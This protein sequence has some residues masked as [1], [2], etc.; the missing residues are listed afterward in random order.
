MDLRCS[1]SETRL[2]EF[3]IITLTLISSRT[4]GNAFASTYL[5]V[6]PCE[7]G[8]IIVAAASQDGEVEG[9]PMSRAWPAQMSAQQIVPMV[10][11]GVSLERGLLT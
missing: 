10:P 9:A 8:V 11:C 4:W 6:L 5:D 3:V 1:A 7:M 2:P